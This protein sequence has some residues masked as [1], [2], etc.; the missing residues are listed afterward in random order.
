[1]GLGL[2]EMRELLVLR[3]RLAGTAV[4][5]PDHQVLLDRLRE[6]AAAAVERC[7]N[8]R[9]Q[10]AHADAFATTLQHEVTRSLGTALHRAVIDKCR[11]CALTVGHRPA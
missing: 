5:A 9:R 1:M 10:L 11:S 2:D 7:E 6:Y 3:D 4:G 8:P